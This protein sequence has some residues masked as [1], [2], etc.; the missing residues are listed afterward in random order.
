MR[1]PYRVSTVCSGNICRS[2]I[3]EAVLRRSLEDAGLGTD[4]VVDSGGTGGW[5]VGSDADPRAL[6]VL[7]QAGYRLDHAAAQVQAGWFG[8]RDLLLAL[9]SGHFREM[10]SMARGEA[11]R[12]KVRMLMEFSPAG[13]GIAPPDRRLDVPD[14]YYGDAAGFDEVLDLVESAAA[15]VVDHV[16][17]VLEGDA[18]PSE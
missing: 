14:P 8:D 15:G 12:A 2:P 3:A 6:R 11:Q 13:R 5:H 1:R 9:D 16:R 18:R 10:R 7:R 4:V 17:A